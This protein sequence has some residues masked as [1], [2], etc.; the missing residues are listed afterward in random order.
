ME[1]RENDKLLP[2]HAK[3]A[4]YPEDWWLDEADSADGL[5]VFAMDEAEDFVKDRQRLKGVPMVTG[6]EALER[7]RGIRRPRRK[8]SRREQ[9]AWEKAQKYEAKLHKAQE[10]EDKKRAKQEAK[11]AAREEKAAKLD[12]MIAASWIAHKE[13]VDQRRDERAWERGLTSDEIS[14]AMGYGTGRYCGD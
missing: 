10:K 7:H 14:K 13:G 9:R 6:Y 5:P 2:E 3:D 4:S 11:L 8:L 1:R 12:A